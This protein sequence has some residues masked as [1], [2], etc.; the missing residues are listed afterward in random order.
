MY[1]SAARVHLIA[2]AKLKKKTQKKNETFFF[3]QNKRYFWLYKFSTNCVFN[4][5]TNILSY[6]FYVMKI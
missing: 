5:K 3:L 4:I 6:H 2:N 1:L